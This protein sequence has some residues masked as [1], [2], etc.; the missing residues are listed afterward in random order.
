MLE[1]G[2]E[3]RR[4]TG[5]SFE[6]FLGNLIKARFFVGVVNHFV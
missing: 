1:T 4:L 5:L 6:D 3:A 2:E